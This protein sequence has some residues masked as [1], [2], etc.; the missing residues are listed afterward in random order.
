[1][2]DTHQ[3]VV[4]LLSRIALFKSL[5]AEQIDRLA[6]RFDLF[7]VDQGFRFFSQGERAD[8]FYLVLSGKVRLSRKTEGGER[9]LATFVSGDHF[10][11]EPL[12]YDLR[13]VATATAVEPSAILRMD[14]E[15]FRWLVMEFPQVKLSLQATIKTRRLARKRTYPWLG[16]DETI[17][18]MARKHQ[19][20]L[21]A[22]LVPP[23]LVGWLS[24][25]CFYLAFEID[26]P[27][28]QL[29]LNWLGG[30]LFFA[31]VL[32]G[33]WIWIDW[34]NDYYIVTNQRVVW[35]EKV[36]GIYDSRQEAPLT[37]VLTVDV[38]TDQISRMLGFGD[39]VVRTFTGH[40][41][42][43]QV[44]YP[45]QLAG[46]LDEFT[47]RSKEVA[48]KIE[49]QML[50]REIRVR[51][52]LPTDPNLPPITAPIVVRPVFKKRPSGLRSS[53]DDFFKVRFEEGGVITF[54]KHWIL[55]VQDTWLPTL[56]LFLLAAAVVGRILE[57]YDVFSTGTV[58]LV[59]FTFGLISLIWWVYQYVD[60]RNDIY[61][62]T[63]DQII[64]IYRKPLGRE[65]KKTAQ[66]E[67]ILSLENKRRGI[68]GLILNYGD[69]IAMVG[70]AKFL[71]Q[72][73][74]SPAS[75]Q[76]EIFHRINERKKQMREA[77]ANRERERIASWL[78]AYHRQ[79]NDLKRLESPPD[80]NQNSE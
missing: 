53:L 7:S 45:Y 68:I 67:N 1:M 78:A 49:S 63:S 25:A 15:G 27:S 38:Q 16:E 43:K 75:V 24:L 71:F 2:Q 33:I 17:Y 52:G 61:Q 34:G 77:E 36:V 32:W 40:I 19:A 58:L 12:L 59:S 70:G 21:Y 55:L 5:N 28:V 48:Q 46:L 30:F 51:L 31:T 56:I 42:M 6:D 10:G 65:D 54:R 35:L 39:V 29:V 44:A 80:D 74:Y 26:K 37:T 13:R 57:L 69:V 47:D 60:W 62:L 9:V 20:A 41:I 23:V 3:Q 76:Q 8:A 18:L 14:K 22:G 79:T 11:E 73:V 4:A 50:E 64:D 72:G 66:L